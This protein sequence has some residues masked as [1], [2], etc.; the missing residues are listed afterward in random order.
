MQLSLSGTATRGTDYTTVPAAGNITV[1]IPAGTYDGTDATAISL[2][3]YIQIAAD[4]T[5]GQAPDSAETII[6]QMQNAS[7]ILIDNG[8]S[9]T[10]GAGP[11]STYTIE[12]SPQDPDNDGVSFEVDLDNDNDGILDTD[13]GRCTNSLFDAGWFGNDPLGTMRQDGYW[14]S[15][16]SGTF[17]TGHNNNVVSTANPF[18]WGSGITATS[19]ATSGSQLAYWNLT[20]VNAASF[21]AAKLRPV[22]LYH[23]RVYRRI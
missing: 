8:S 18:N 4:N 23:S 13:E 5:I 3:P 20:G 2:A 21:P 11:G 17:N 15:A 1:T 16:P 9:C 12:P 19:W 10:P 7:N 14:P 6:M 22:F